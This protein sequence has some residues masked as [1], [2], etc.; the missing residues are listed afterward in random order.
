[1]VHLFVNPGKVKRRPG[2]Y[3]NCFKYC[4]QLDLKYGSRIKSG[5]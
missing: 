1:M 4:T 2:I 3:W 5:M